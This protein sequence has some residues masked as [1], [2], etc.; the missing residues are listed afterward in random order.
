[1]Y[2]RFKKVVAVGRNC[3]LCAFYTVSYRKYSK[4]VFTSQCICVS[5][6]DMGILPRLW[7]NLIIQI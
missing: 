4:L 3:R 7:G 2:V 1:M 6:R 5:S